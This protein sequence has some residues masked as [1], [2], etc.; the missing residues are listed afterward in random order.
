[1]LSKDTYTKAFLKEAELSQSLLD[2]K[3]YEWWLNI[4]DEGGLRLTELG[5][6]FLTTTL[7]LQS[8]QIKIPRDVIMSPT[9]IL[10]M[11]HYIRCPYYFNRKKHLLVLYGEHQASEMMLYGDDLKLFFDNYATEHFS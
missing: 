5:S 7:D 8:Y 10:V 6:Q 9:N 4:R 1:M 11:D 2:R 3:K